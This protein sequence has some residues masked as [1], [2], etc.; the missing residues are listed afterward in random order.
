MA[1]WCAD[2]EVA[3]GFLVVKRFDALYREF[4]R[5]PRWEMPIYAL[6]RFGTEP[7]RLSVRYRGLDRDA[8]RAAGKGRAWA[9]AMLGEVRNAELMGEGRDGFLA[10]YEQ[11]LD[12]LGW[13]DEETPGT[14]EIVWTQIAHQAAPPPSAF[15]RLGFEPTYFT[16]D[17]FSA[18]CDCMCFPRWHGTD[19]QGVLF[20]AHFAQL[21]ANGLFDEA[22]L[23]A[24]FLA[25]YL[26]FDWT[27]TGEYEIASVWI[28]S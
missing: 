25:Y 4:A 3:S 16:G 9:N 22:A 11:A 28:P 12:V 14:Y 5:D 15:V 21:N 20:Q 2:G 23:A 8:L 24:E 1:A 18:V 10:S 19:P 13:Q 17:H 26:S 27:E 7:D 6:P